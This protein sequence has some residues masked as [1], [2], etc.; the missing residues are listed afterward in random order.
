MRPSP[1]KVRKQYWAIPGDTW[2]RKVS[3]GKD[4][5]LKAMFRRGPEEQTPN[6][7]L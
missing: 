6:S 2:R 5:I 3:S 7:H 1:F 4:V